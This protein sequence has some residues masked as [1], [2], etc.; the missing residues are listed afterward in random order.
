M[1]SLKHLQKEVANFEKKAGFERTSKKQLIAWLEEE[2]QNYKNEK[3]KSRREN[4]L[5]DIIILAAQLANR[6]KADLDVVLDKWW[7]KSGKY[8]KEN[9][10]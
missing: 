8:I 7:K 2:I 9:K 4:K 5:M 6:E 1:T 3:S 10:K